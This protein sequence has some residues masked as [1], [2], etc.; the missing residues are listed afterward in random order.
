MTEP[1]PVV[2]C[3]ECGNDPTDSTLHR[4]DCPR[5]NT[6]GQFGPPWNPEPWHPTPEPFTAGWLASHRLLWREA[7]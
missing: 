3:P 7:G 1:E 4:P 2:P 6:C 5:V